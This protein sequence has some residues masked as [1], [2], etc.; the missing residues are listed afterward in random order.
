MERLSFTYYL[1]AAHQAERY[2][3]SKMDLG[4][5]DSVSNMLSKAVIGNIWVKKAVDQG[6]QNIDK[7]MAQ[8]KKL[9]PK[10]INPAVERN[11]GRQDWRAYIDEMAFEARSMGAGNCGEQAALAFKYLEEQ[12]IR[13]LDYV[14]FRTRNHA[15]VILGSTVPIRQNNFAEWS[16]EGVV[17]DPWGKW[18]DLAGML[19]VKYPN[20][21][22]ES[23][24]H[25][26]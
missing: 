24:F 6:R 26:G 3:I 22:F 17:C 21:R 18:V 19:A 4:A 14:A 15:I 1:N 7:R 11:A 13:P 2:V 12:G 8:R 25:V 23:Q 10:A 20:S 16:V 9:D 5:N